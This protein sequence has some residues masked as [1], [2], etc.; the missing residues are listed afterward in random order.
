M[1]KRDRRGVPRYVE[2][3]VEAARAGAIKPG[4]ARVVR[5]MHDDW[6]ALLKGKGQCN[7]NPDI[8]LGP[9]VL[10]GDS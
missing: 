1:K 9:D 6:C 4:E 3:I 7:C 2:R 5:V 10:R 8:E